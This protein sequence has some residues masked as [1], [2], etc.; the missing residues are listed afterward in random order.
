MCTVVIAS[1]PEVRVPEEETDLESFR[2]WA[3]S[4]EFPECG[5][6]VFLQ[7]EVWIDMSPERLQSHALLKAQFYLE[8]GRLV[9]DADLGRFFPDGALWTHVGANIS[10]EPDALFVTWEAHESGR[11]KY[12]G[13]PEKAIEIQGSPDMVLEIVSDSSVRK[14][15]GKICK[16]TE[17]G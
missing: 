4:K 16:R 13:K 7:G 12:V 8:L 11:V 17:G 14:D 10:T 5:K 1:E 9:R 15:E 6:I 2:H 3:Y